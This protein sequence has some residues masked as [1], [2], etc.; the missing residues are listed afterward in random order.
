MKISI[1]TPS[2]NS[3]KYLERAIQ[4]VLQQ[5]YDNWEHIVVDGGSTDNT[6]EILKRYPHIKW[7]SEPDKG[8]SD[9]MNKAFAM[10]SGEIIMYL[11]ADDEIEKNVFGLIIKT[12][13][14]QTD[15]DM[16]IGSLRFV[17]QNE[18]GIIRTPSDSLMKI[19]RYKWYGE[20]Y[21]PG[22]PVSYY[23]KRHIQEKI[24]GY[25]LEN[26]YT[27]DYEFLLN[28]YVISKIYKINQVLGTFYCYGDNKSSNLDRAY[29]SL[30]E[31]KSRFF[32]KN[33]EIYEKFKQYDKQENRKEFIENIIGKFTQK[34]AIRT[35]LKKLFN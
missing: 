15:C 30:D 11:N 3:G 21:F 1:L 5:D 16:I 8:Q 34:L 24:G 9:A 35:R 6:I 18:S 17:W 28:A 26:H 29:K 33:K 31:T 4:S 27:M 25:S 7:V 13:R 14:E 2:F 20:T 22:N 12:F 19:L 23:Y 32:E 10:S